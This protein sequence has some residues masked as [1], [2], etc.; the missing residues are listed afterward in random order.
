M[1]LQYCF[2]GFPS[3]LLLSLLLLSLLSLLK[4][5]L[6]SFL[7]S[8]SVLLLSLLSLLSLLLS[9]LLFLL[10]LLLLLSL[11]S[12]SLLSLL[13]SL[14]SLLLYCSRRCATRILPI[15]SLAGNDVFVLDFS[16]C[17]LDENGEAKDTDGEDPWEKID[18]VLSAVCRMGGCVEADD[19]ERRCG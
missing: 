16:Q 8:L 9:L 10:L 1:L 14:L 19:E 17:V 2:D 7:P 15:C 6:L 4:S 11:L 3:L 13:L 12:S 18:E 5:L